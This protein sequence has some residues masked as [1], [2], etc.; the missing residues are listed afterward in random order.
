[1]RRNDAACEGECEQADRIGLIHIGSKLPRTNY[2]S[3]VNHRISC[4]IRWWASFHYS[5]HRNA[6]MTR[7]LLLVAAMALPMACGGSSVYDDIKRAL[8]PGKGDLMVN[9]NTA[10]L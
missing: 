5:T 3:A 7:S 2:V 6:R 10:M 8:E 4:P 1:M 9:V